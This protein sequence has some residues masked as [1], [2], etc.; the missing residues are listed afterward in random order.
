MIDWA[1]YPMLAFA[2]AIGTF[3]F[4]VLFNVPRRT[5]LFATFVGVAGQVVSRFL[6]DVGLSLEA[7]AFVGGL[8]VGLLAE[9]GA[10]LFH[11]PSTIFTIT[12]FIPLVPGALAFRAVKEFL[13]NQ[14]LTGLVIAVRAVVI[15]SAI[16]AGLAAVA[17]INQ[18]RRGPLP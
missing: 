4:A 14:V 5:L 3:S 13:D 2:A 16:A 1:P 17:A 7:A 6:S 10:R 8:T 9:M 12:G 11:T 15:G 18:L